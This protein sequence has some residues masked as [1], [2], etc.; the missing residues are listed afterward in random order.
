M[1]VR[2]P[3]QLVQQLRPVLDL[4]WNN[5]EVVGWTVVN[6]YFGVSIQDHSPERRNVLEPY[7]IVFGFGTVGRSIHHLQEPQPHNQNAKYNEH[8]QGGDLQLLAEDL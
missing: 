8:K 4:F 7:S 1:D 3:A 2:K 5:V 6:K